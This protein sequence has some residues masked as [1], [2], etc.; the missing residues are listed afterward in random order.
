M[1]RKLT[2]DDIK[3]RY[4]EFRQLVHFDPMG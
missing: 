2:A 3:Q 4:D 1:F